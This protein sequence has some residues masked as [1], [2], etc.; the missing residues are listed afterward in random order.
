M[1]LLLEP[2]SQ[3]GVGVRGDRHPGA[4]MRL[5]DRAQH[6]LDTR[7]DAGLVGGALED[8]GL[9]AGVGDSLLDVADEHV[10]HDLRAAQHPAGALVVEAEWNVVVGVQASRHD[11]VQV[12]GR[13]DTG[14]ARDV[15]AQS[16][17]GEV[18]DGVD[19]ARLQFVEPID[20]IGHPFVF[21]SP[22][23]R[24]VHRDLGGHDEHVFVHERDAE[25]SGI[26]RSL[27]GIH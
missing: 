24:V 15:A 7:G 22:C 8:A 18:D 5:G 19:A 26:D 25:I 3:S 4:L 27:S 6:P 11:D 16:D 21:V 20:G 1:L 17:H 23:L 9:D 2:A 10:G 13:G 14:D 12:G